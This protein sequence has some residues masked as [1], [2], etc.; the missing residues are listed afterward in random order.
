MVEWIYFKEVEIM[1][2][3]R[4]ISFML[5]LGLTLN[6]LFRY[7]ELV[8]YPKAS[9]YYYYK[10]IER[11]TV[12]VFCIGSSHVYCSI[13]PVQMYDDYGI[14][15]YDLAAGSQAIWHSYYYIKEMLKTQKPSIVILDVYTLICQDDYFDSKVE[16]NL[17]NMHPSYNKWEALKMSDSE[18]NFDI[19]WEFPIVHSRYRDLNKE[20][21]NLNKN[22]SYFLGYSYQTRIVPYSM[23]EIVDIRGGV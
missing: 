11:E 3:K 21:F 1:W 5:L 13:N 18:D 19:F 9:L 14:A 7:L 10:Y 22:N 16:M 17:L 8:Q 23:D 12:D 4:I 6:V 2:L 15:A 20:S